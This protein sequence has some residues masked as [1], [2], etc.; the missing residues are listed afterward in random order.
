MLH[1]LVR[2]FNFCDF[3]HVFEADRSYNLMAWLAC[4]LL[5]AGCSF[6]EV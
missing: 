1:V 3:I 6:Q 5:K 2:S 4:T